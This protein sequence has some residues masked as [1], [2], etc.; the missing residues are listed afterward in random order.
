MV[1]LRKS[2]PY[3]RPL[4]IGETISHYRILEKLGGGGMGV[5]YKAEDTRLHRFVA[6]KFLPESVARD[7]QALSRFQREAQAASA[8]NHPNICTIYDIG[9]ADGRA[10][11]VM[12]YLE[13]LT[14]KHTIHSA[15]LDLETLLRVALDVTDA[16]DAAH[17]KGIVHRDIKPANIFVTSRGHGKILDFGLAK[18][19]A[20]PGDVTQTSPGAD[21]LTD[22]GS[23]VGTVAYMSPEQARGKP[24]DS[25]TD[26]FSFGA[27]LYEM[28]TGTLPFRG[29]TTALLFESIL[30]KA[31]V[32]PVR[33]NPDLPTEL[34]RIINKGLEKDR[35][36]R[37]QHA[38]DM[39]ADLKRLKR[40]VQSSGASGV[41]AED[42]AASGLAA[43]A[44]KRDSSKGAAAAS[45]GTSAA[46]STSRA[47]LIWMVAAIVVVLAVAAAGYIYTHRPAPKL[48]EK[49]TIVV[50]DFAN[51]TGDPVFDDALKQALSVSLRQ[52]PFL[53]V[54][55]DEKVAATLKLMTRPVSTPLIP[56]VARELCQRAD[57]KAYLAGSIASLGSQYV[58]G[59]KAVNCLNGDVLAEEQATATGK[60]KVLDVLGEAAGK[61]RGQLGESLASVQKFDAP[62]AQETTPSLEALKAVSIGRKIE[63]EK[64]SAAALPAYQHA[65]DLD[66]NFASAIEGVGIM[67]GNLG[68]PTRG[69]DYLSKAFALRDHASERE[70][71][72]IASM[73][74]MVDTGELDKA[75]ETFREWE[76][77]YPRDDT[78]YINL[79]ALY[80]FEGKMEQGM[81]QTRDALRLNPDNVIAVEDLLAFQL[82][83]DRFDEARQLYQQAMAR[84]LDDDT[85]HMVLYSV[86]FIEKNPKGMA[87]QAAWFEG[88]PELQHEIL[89]QE[90]D[91]EAYAGHVD[92]A[93]ELTHRA[94]EAAVRADNKESAA[95]W[96][97]YSAWREA[98]FGNLEEAKREAAAG[99]ALA[100][101]SQSAQELAAPVFARAGETARAN[102]LAQELAKRYPIHTIVQSYW[103]PTIAAQVAL[104]A[105]VPATA[106]AQLRNTANLEY[107]ETVGNSNSSCLYPAY[108][109]G[110]A[111]L[112]AGQEGATA[113]FQKVIDHPGIVVNCVTGALAH[114]ELGRSYA[115]AGDKTKAKA[116]Y[117]D[118]LTL[119]KDADPDIPVLKEAKAEFAK[120]Q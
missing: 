71:L 98:L 86:E 33:L 36:L 106:I 28:A 26:L 89:A 2:R 56:D 70:K 15:P 39:R 111:Y 59:L 83:L 62:L 85:L 27:V 87:E 20:V 110:E 84:K 13:G 120:L 67:Y 45:S 8:L 90:S 25:R 80:A 19:T 64:G 115:L 47:K 42:E 94:V 44:V 60:E 104:S 17:T 1:R 30:H 69:E 52:S 105:K 97:L 73:Y 109:R 103:L 32:A 63:R 46:T 18:V 81:D 75:I 12:E 21:Q 72:H 119:W 92:K 43:S 93:R 49:D 82:S 4:M 38:S 9:E 91:T 57:S 41:A 68:Q 88:R 102:T 6:L 35:D 101:D 40:G 51:S 112:A 77:N 65:I 118:F 117:Q 24:L 108:L 29:D 61:L 55:S 53:N 22:A 37:Y 50:G 16:L 11:I 99:L 74:Y 14:L 113:E 34:E 48:T 114:L 5:V 7:P 58:L 100:P 76:E 96:Q 10:Y 31:P 79:S 23:T 54:L 116:A 95:V 78:S 107:G 3:A 66:P